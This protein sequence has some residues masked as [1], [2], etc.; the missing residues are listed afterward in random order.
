M[1]LSCL[2]I[3]DYRDCVKHRFKKKFRDSMKG[4]MIEESYFIPNVGFMEL[5][6]EVIS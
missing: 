6:E 3:A 1:S 4:K 2:F 5:R